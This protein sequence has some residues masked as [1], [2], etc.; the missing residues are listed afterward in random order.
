[1]T[2]AVTTVVFDV[3]NVLIE[4]DPDHLYREL[5]PDLAER[6]RFLTEICSMEWNLEQDLGRDWASAIS[7]LVARHPDHAD[8][9]EAYSNRWHDM[10][11]GEIAGTV[12]I[13]SE[14]K[15]SEI[16][17]YA[18]TN[19]SSEKFAEAQGR[20]PFLASSFSDI[21][22]SAEERVLKPDR[23]IFD[24]LLNRNGLEASS[25]V[26]IDDSERNI[27]GARAAGLKALHFTHPDTLR[28]DLKQMGFPV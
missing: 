13:L 15:A 19:F 21:V 11:P 17:L 12:A 3:G 27:D 8:L 18:I 22:I 10:V 25:C 24:T 26:F 2:N 28:Q 6:H 1:M 5:I 23:R 14:L 4:W 9:I 16:P 20:F 7:E